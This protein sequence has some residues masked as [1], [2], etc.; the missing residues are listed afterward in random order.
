MNGTAVT[1]SSVISATGNLP[2]FELNSIGDFN[3]DGQA[4]FVLGGIAPVND[5]YI[6][7]VTA[8]AA[9]IARYSTFILSAPWIVV[10]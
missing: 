8:Y 3:G 4:D 9:Q 10:P 1:G 5:G 2:D 7:I 6:Y